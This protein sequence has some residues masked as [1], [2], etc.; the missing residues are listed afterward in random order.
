[1]AVSHALVVFES[2]FGNT[3]DVARAVGDGLARH[4]P[5]DVLEVGVAP[6]GPAEDVDL[7]VVGGPTHAFALSR[8]STRRDAADRRALPPVSAGIGVREWL[9]EFSPR[10]DLSGAAFGTRVATPWVPG[11]AANAIGRRLRRRGVPLVAP[12]CSFH[13]SGMEGP[14][15]EGELR[16]AHAWGEELAAALTVLADRAR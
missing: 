11:S 12:T 3:E 13:V 16:R 10:P 2:M 9:A 5:V 6:A 14:L 15:V 1:V 4:M 8:S 7:L